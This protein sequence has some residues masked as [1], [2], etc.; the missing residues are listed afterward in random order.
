MNI[1]A[2]RNAQPV[3]TKSNKKIDIN[4]IR[5]IHAII[6]N[7]I[8]TESAGVFRR[9]DMIGIMG[10]DLRVTPHIE[11]ENDLKNLI[12]TYYEN[13]EKGNHP[14]EEAVLFHYNFE[15]IHP[16]I[17]GNGRVGRELF[18]YL[19]IKSKPSY[20]KLLFLGKDRAKYIKALKLGNDGEYAMMISFFEDLIINQR[21]KVLEGNL[22]KLLKTPISGRQMRLSD[23]VDI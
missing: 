21:L 10:C 7:N 20:P 11:I 19:L 5:D 2:L 8:D 18:N 6:M 1:Q 3:Q 17:D 9:S 4:F 16:F 13:L 15:L 22:E 14:F 23:F 12:R